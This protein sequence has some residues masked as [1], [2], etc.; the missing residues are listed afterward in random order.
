MYTSSYWEI[1]AFWQKKWDFVI[2]GSGI[3]GFTTAQEIKTKYP[4]ADILI[5]ERGIL[6]MGAS[7]R[8]AGV[9]CFG[10]ISELL[11]QESSESQQTMLDLVKLRFTGLERL[12][13]ITK[14]KDIGYQP[15]GGYEVFTT[16]EEEKYQYYLT[17]L[18]RI[19]ALLEP[20]TH[21]KQTYIPADER[22]SE[23]GLKNVTHL[24]YNP[25]EGLLHSGKLVFTLWQ[26]AQKMGIS[27]WNQME[28]QALNPHST[29]VEITLKQGKL[30]ANKVIVTTNAF[31][32]QLL[33]ELDVVPG[34]GQVCVTKPITN[35]KLKGAFHYEEGYYYFRSVED[36]RVLLGGGRNLDFKAEE[37]YAFGFTELVQN[38]LKTLLK[39]VILPDTAFEI[40]HWWSGIMGFGQEKSP[41]IREVMPN[42]YCAVRMSGMGVAIG[43]KVA[44]K[45]AEMV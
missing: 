25:A 17:Q 40:E 18:D 31:A 41:I 19:N 34:R 15:T 9:A 16:S 33:P 30:Y 24:I 39:E 26:I 45:V 22:I 36:N 32:K 35:L 11:L 12:F 6:P 5:L 38:Q 10:S 4:D 14:G 42:V 1:S 3:V 37:T 27:V 44:Q 23:L 2:I 8:N 7:T 29:D 43:S 28:V 20:I 21:L 13:E